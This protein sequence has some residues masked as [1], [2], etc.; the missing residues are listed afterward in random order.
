MKR[1]KTPSIM[2]IPS[3]KTAPQRIHHLRGIAKACGSNANDAVAVAGENQ[4]MYG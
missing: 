4:A 3:L 1:T 2:D